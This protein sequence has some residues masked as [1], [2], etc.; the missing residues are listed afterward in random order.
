MSSL[1]RFL[2]ENPSAIIEDHAARATWLSNLKV[3]WGLE[4]ASIHVLLISLCPDPA[5]AHVRPALRRRG[6]PKVPRV[7]C[8]RLDP[9]PHGYDVYLV[10]VHV[11]VDIVWTV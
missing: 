11:H 3:R 10:H 9:K 1:L 5:A 8:V 2:P 7:D 4:H 6:G